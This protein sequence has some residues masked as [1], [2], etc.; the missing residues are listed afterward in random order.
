MLPGTASLRRSPAR[1]KENI[2]IQLWSQ[3][4]IL[5]EGILGSCRQIKLTCLKYALWDMARGMTWLWSLGERQ[6]KAEQCCLVFEKLLGQKGMDMRNQSGGAEGKPTPKLEHS[7]ALNGFPW[8][9][10]CICW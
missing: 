5:K 3:K 9:G 4:S 2:Q 1:E 6:E 7:V 10:L 8:T